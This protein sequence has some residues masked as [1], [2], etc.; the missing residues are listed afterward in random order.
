MYGPL[1]AAI[2]TDDDY[3]MAHGGHYEDLDDPNFSM[4]KSGVMKQDQRPDQPAF[5]QAMSGLQL[6]SDGSSVSFAQT[7]SSTKAAWQELGH[8][9]LIV[10]WKTDKETKE[11]V[12]IC[13]NSYGDHWGMRGDFYVR[14][15]MDD[16]GLESE[17]ESHQV[18]LIE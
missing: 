10:G 6:S 12:W 9:V 16:F 1:V 17:V 18:E 15:G 7:G 4:Y 11:K 8:S 5:A 3:S 2:N 14:R 13:R